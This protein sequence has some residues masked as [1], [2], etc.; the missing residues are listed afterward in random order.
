MSDNFEYDHK[1]GLTARWTAAVR[2][3][4]NSREDRLFTDP[5]AASLAGQEGRDWVE[6]RS[7]DSLTPIILRTRFFDDFLKHITVENQI[8]QVI[9]VAA[10]LDTRAFRL[11]WPE[12]TKIFELDQTSVLEWKEASLSSVDARP[13]CERRAVNVD[14]TGSWP[15]SLIS[16][17]FNPEQPSGWLLEGFLFY[18]PN[19]NILDLLSKLSQLAVSGSW[20]GFDIVNKI[21]LTHPLTQPWIEMQAKAGAPWLGSMDD[22]IGYL[23]AQGWKATL[24]QAGQPEANHGRWTFPIVPATMPDMPHNWFV[25]AEKE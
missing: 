19:E 16:A 18:I 13:N 24:T 10:G 20:L 6:G 2:A 4:E 17:G 22:P 1:L 9:L 25:T 21:S 8:Y 15:D 5:W 12:Q 14:L 3:A 7:I 11:S 23:A